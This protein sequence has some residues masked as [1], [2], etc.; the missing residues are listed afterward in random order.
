MICFF[1]SAHLQMGREKIYIKIPNNYPNK[2][3][4]LTN[5]SWLGRLHICEGVTR[6]KKER[7]WNVTFFKQ[8]CSIL[9]DKMRCLWKLQQ[10]WFVQHVL[11]EASF[12]WVH[13]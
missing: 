8:C 10:L 2:V 9:T 1:S 12:G 4:S 5:V 3:K 6:E 13:V 7:K 11:S